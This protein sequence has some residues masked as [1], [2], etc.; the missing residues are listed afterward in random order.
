MR[1]ENLPEIVVESQFL[2]ELKAVLRDDETVEHFVE[3]AVRRAVQIRRSEE[4]FRARGEAAWQEYQRTGKSFP[5]DDVLTEL[6]AM[7][8][9]RRKQLGDE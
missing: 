7:T 8:A 3:E 5:L 9:M 1:T 6:R 2:A 4:A